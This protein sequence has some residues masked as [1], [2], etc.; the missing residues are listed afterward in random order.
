MRLIVACLFLAVG[1]ASCTSV[2]YRRE[3]C[4]ALHAKEDPVDVKPALPPETCVRI[5]LLDV[6]GSEMSGSAALTRAAQKAAARLGAD[7][8]V[9]EESGVEKSLKSDY[10]TVGSLVLP[11]LRTARHPWAV[12]SV[13]CYTPADLGIKLANNRVK[14]FRLG[15]EAEE[16]GLVVG[17]Q[18][19]G[20]DGIDV[21]DEEF[22]IH[23]F[24]I[25]PGAIVQL[26]V[27]RQGQR[28]DIPLQ[29]GV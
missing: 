20:I 21:D 28:L 3:V 19:L 4:V 29:A 16:C 9:L 14:G 10:T 22:K 2:S 18:L 27:R 6:S 23:L 8:V 12:Y 11:L 5:G 15:S 7:F 25:E 17:D 24:Q 1:L 13:W 26:H